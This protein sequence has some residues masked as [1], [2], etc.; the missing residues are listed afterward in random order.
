MQMNTRGAESFLAGEVETVRKSFNNRSLERSLQILCA[1]SVEK[2][3]LSLV[4]LSQTLGI[5]KPTVY[6]LCSTLIQH[7]FLRYNGRDRR[8]S[9]GLRLF[10][11]G[12]IVFSS[13]SV[14]K[15][16]S[17][18]LTDLQSKTGETVFLAILQGDDLVYIDKREDERKPI[19]IA[20]N[21][22]T[23][24]PPHFGMFGQ[25]LMAY[26]DDKEI[27]RILTAHPLKSFTERSITDNRTFKK[28]LERIRNQGFHVDREEALQGVIGI[29]APIRD[30]TRKVIAAVGVAFVS[31]SEDSRRT[32]NLIKHVCGAA[33]NISE[34]L[35][36]RNIQGNK[37]FKKTT[38]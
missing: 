36:Y 19:R 15:K 3:E 32:K 35:G 23:I 29:A 31:A 5:P 22:G 16:A 12:A 33:R 6:R 14:R 13:F 34:E 20:S 10:T 38:N 25:V 1:F 27:D 26:L 28:R 7:D 21:I 17:L 4:E 8:Y 11:L 24:R 37:T 2:K 9:L 18:Y 30:Y